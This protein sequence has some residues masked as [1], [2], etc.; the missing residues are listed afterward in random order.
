MF[1]KIWDYIANRHIAPNTDPL[2]L[3]EAQRMNLFAF[4]IGAVLIFNGCRD[5]LFGL[6]INFFALSALGIF[7]LFLFFFT[8]VRYNIFLTLFSLE[9]FLFLIFFFHPL[10]GLKTVFHYIIL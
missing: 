10:Q 5:L 8:K 7:Y 6:K 9:L 2:E 4:S 3:I 1:R